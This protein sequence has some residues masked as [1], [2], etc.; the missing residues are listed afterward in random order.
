MKLSAFAFLLISVSFGIDGFSQMEINQRDEFGKPHGPWKKYYEG[1]QQLRYEGVFEHGKE[2]GEFRFYCEDCKDRPSAIKKFTAEDDVSEIEY[3]SKKGNLIST[4][5][6]HGK[7]RA[8]EWVTFHE[9]S[10]VPMVQ[11]TYLEGKLHGKQ[12]TFY[13]DGKITSEV[14]YSNGVKDGP[15]LYYAPNGVVI[16]RLNYKN[17][18]LH[19]PVSYYDAHGNLTI[20]GSYKEDRKHGLWRYYKDGKVV[21]EETFPNRNRE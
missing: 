16:K 18:D 5:K 2:T 20:E 15:N 7:V 17:G 8:G 19:G 3:Y 10:R 9:D 21:S 11:E 12:T 6:M 4:G 13:P 1:T 14:T